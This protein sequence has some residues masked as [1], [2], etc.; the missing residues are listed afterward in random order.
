[1][2]KLTPADY[3]LLAEL[4]HQI[5]RFVHFSESAARAAGVEPRQHQLMLALKG[6]PA[7]VRPRISEVAERLQIQHHSAVELVNR[8]CAAG[9]VRREQGKD[10]REV[11]LALTD[12]GEKVLQELS[13]C[14]REELRMQG[15]ALV[16][17]LNKLITGSQSSRKP[18]RNGAGSKPRR[19]L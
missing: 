6:L 9:Y 15:P 7:G 19:A 1:M 14:H 10:R 11:W 4:R 2:K 12:K 5:R 16:K 3:G 18:N 17:T 8:L 13:L